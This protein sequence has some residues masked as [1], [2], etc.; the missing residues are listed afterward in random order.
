MNFYAVLIN[1]HYENSIASGTPLPNVAAMGPWFC[2]VLQR[3]ALHTDP[4]QTRFGQ[5]ANYFMNGRLLAATKICFVVHI[6]GHWIAG[7][8]SHDEK[9]IKFQ[10][11]LGK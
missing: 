10:D 6:P 7:V 5:L 8:L 11:S 4:T 3:I 9:L 1:Q 2:D